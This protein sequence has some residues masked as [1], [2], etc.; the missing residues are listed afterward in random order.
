MEQHKWLEEMGDYAEIQLEVSRLEFD[1]ML[2]RA[3]K[4]APWTHAVDPLDWATEFHRD[5]HNED[6][7]R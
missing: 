3:L 2:D 6:R 5:R 7:D 1:A 4:E